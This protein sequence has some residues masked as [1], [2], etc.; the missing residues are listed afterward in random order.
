MWRPH[1]GPPS[2]RARP[3]ELLTEASG[4]RS[5]LSVRGP[6]QPPLH[7]QYT[8]LRIACRR[9]RRRRRR[10]R[11]FRESSDGHSPHAV[12]GCSVEPRRVGKAAIGPHSQASGDAS[13]ISGRLP[14]RKPNFLE[15]T[16]R[17][18]PSRC[19]STRAARSVCILAP[20]IQS[21]IQGCDEDK[22]SMDCCDTTI[23]LL[24]DL[25]ISVS[26]SANNPK[27]TDGSEAS[28]ILSNSTIQAQIHDKE[29]TTPS[30]KPGGQFLQEEPSTK[31]NT[32]CTGRKYGRCPMNESQAKV[33]VDKLLQVCVKRSTK[34]L[35]CK[36]QALVT[37]A[38]PAS[39]NLDAKDAAACLQLPSF[40][41][42]YQLEL[43][44]TVAITDCN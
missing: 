15:H 7:L 20:E 9:R 11:A 44:G 35:C 42:L 2:G 21:T 25:R 29:S 32:S 5:W 14:S 13:V 12:L 22:W 36:W 41:T 38:F 27:D 6:E 33:I 10:R 16:Q 24:F 23:L 40:Q 3:Q 17:K 37:K 31:H 19:A 8:H 28:C 30:R 34:S 43:K 26:C 18:T 4:R 39:Q 1:S